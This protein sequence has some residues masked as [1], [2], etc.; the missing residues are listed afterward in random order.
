MAARRTSASVNGELDRHVFVLY[1]N[2]TPGEDQIVSPAQSFV[3]RVVQMPL[4]YLGYET[5]Y[6]NC[7]HRPLPARLPAGTAAV[8]LDGFLRLPPDLEKPLADWV[9]HQRK[10]GARVLVFG[11]VPFDDDKIRA[12]FLSSLGV[13]GSGR[14][15]NQ[16]KEVR[17]TKVSDAMNFEAPLRTKTSDV[18]DIQMPETGTAFLSVSAKSENKP[19][20][21]DPIFA[22]DWGGFA[23]EP[24]LLFEREDQVNL[25]LLDPFRFLAAALNP[26]DWPVPDSTTRDGL[27]LFYSH[28]DGDGFSDKS[29]VVAGRRSPEVIRDEILAKY[30]VPVTVSVIESEIDGQLRGQEPG[31][32]AELQ[33]I[34]KSIF[35]L[36][37]VQVASHTYTH[38][39]YWTDNS[40]DAGSY[41][42]RNLNLAN[43]TAY[44]RI[45]Y[46]RE[47]KGSID[48]ISQN[49]TTKPV[50]V[51]LWSGD[52]DPPPKAI[53]ITTESHV[54]N[55]NGGDTLIAAS[56]PSITCVAPR[57]VAWDGQLQ[58]YA[59]NQNEDVYTN[60]WRGPLFGTFAHVI[61][62][63]ERTETP[64]RLKPVD[65]Y[66]H[67]Y[68]G[69]K[70]ESIEA[71]RKVYDWAL[72]QPLHSVTAATYIR[73]AVD[74]RATRIIREGPNQWRIF[75]NGDCRTFRLPFRGLYPDL[76]ASSGVVG[77]NLVG[78]TMYV[79]TAG[80]PETRIAL[81]AKPPSFWHLT[82]STSEINIQQFNR[83]QIAFHISDF[84]PGKVAIDGAQPSCTATLAGPHGKT[85]VTADKHGRFTLNLLENGDFRLE[86]T[87]ANRTA[88]R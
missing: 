67:F 32:K 11:Q 55:M 57:T 2:D 68:S 76:E 8:V 5:D 43:P 25:W 63:F 27:R 39:F 38:P 81:S 7:L 71:L 36:P 77:Y 21:F 85:M 35:S 15:A 60:D 58:V 42:S 66:Y 6:W 20:A 10:L 17:F 12:S 49:L 37:N 22:A 54:L 61:D 48:Y 30:P 3:G 72:A 73:I 62:T 1:G 44:Q 83:N 31:D 80:R 52:C 82:S 13:K 56:K 41:H 29:E 40:P 19:I 34:A 47:I 24:Y 87:D 88:Q 50:E 46:R 9:I 78:D 74:A 14:S 45:D 26:P 64:R 33:E 69:D 18:Y 59:A 70:F 65:I 51:L 84:R 16:P 53:A 28:I 75:N 79:N 4:E 23:L 86:A